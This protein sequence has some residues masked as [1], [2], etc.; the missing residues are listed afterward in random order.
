MAQEKNCKVDL[1]AKLH[2]PWSGPRPGP[3]PPKK[4]FQFGNRALKYKNVVETRFDPD[5]VAR[6]KVLYLAP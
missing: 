3:R 6:T 5:D 4:V 2:G 1:L